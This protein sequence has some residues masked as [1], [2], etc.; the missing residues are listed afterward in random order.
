MTSL[1]FL[2]KR[3]LV[4]QSRSSSLRSLLYRLDQTSNSRKFHH[5]I[6][7]DWFERQYK[8]QEVNSRS[9]LVF[10]LITGHMQ[11]NRKS[12][13]FGLQI[14]S[15]QGRSFHDRWSRR[16][17]T[18]NTRVACFYE[19]LFSGTYRACAKRIKIPCLSSVVSD[20]VDFSHMNAR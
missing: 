13:I 2:Y 4:F 5:R 12:D 6:D 15:F 8:W 10:H 9:S 11:F 7:F 20:R 17:K 16:T 3:W 1:L 19:S 18:L 14:G